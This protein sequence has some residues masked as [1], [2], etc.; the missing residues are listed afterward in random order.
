MNKK[1][2]TLFPY[3]YIDSERLR[4]TFFSPQK[5]RA[6]LKKKKAYSKRII[7]AAIIA[8]LALIATIGT[9]AIKYEF[10]VIPRYNNVPDNTRHSLL[11]NRMKAQA[12]LVKAGQ[13]TTISGGPVYF[14]IPT[15]E[16]TRIVIN[17]EKAV[18]LST[19]PLLMYF[20]KADAPIRIGVVAR[21][22]QFFS[23][24]LTPL[25][26]ELTN[27]GSNA[28]VKIPIVF[29]NAH[30]QNTNLSSINQISLYFYPPQNNESTAV[31]NWVIIKDLVL[32]KKEAK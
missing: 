7:A 18:N 27:Q 25:S 24:S 23:N 29:S 1:T 32:A 11:R 8:G 3:S 13:R 14:E 10:V 28:F 4:E 16:P 2:D 30:L 15:Q 19:A 22:T 17:L 20:K 5:K 6:P 21:D 26:I 31:K 12:T 9:L